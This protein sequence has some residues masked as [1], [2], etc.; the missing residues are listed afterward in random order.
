M[1]ALGGTSKGTSQTAIQTYDKG[2][3]RLKNRCTISEEYEA[4]SANDLWLPI[5]WDEIVC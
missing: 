1:V 2:R 4:N 5:E 3:E